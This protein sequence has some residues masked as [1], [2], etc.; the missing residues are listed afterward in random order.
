MK[1]TAFNLGKSLLTVMRG[2]TL[3]ILIVHLVFIALGFALFTPLLG[4]LSRLLLALSSTEV[5]ADTDIIFFV[6]SPYGMIAL[7]LFG[8]MLIT[9]LVFEQAAMML[10]YI[11]AQKD[12]QEDII[13]MIGYTAARA[14]VIFK[15]SVLLIIRLL[16]IVLPFLAVG[17]TVAWLALTKYDINYYLAHKPPVFYLAALLI[18]AILLLMAFV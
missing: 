13:R 16:I 6:L 12:T 7:M 3:S 10:T 9:I 4:A 1:E 17:A 14:L 8:A 18:G 2:N 5:L 11:A 15:F